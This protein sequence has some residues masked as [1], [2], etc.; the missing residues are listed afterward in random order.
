MSLT[1]VS[2]K[3]RIVIPKDARAG[4]TAGQTIH[5]FAKDGVI[6]LV[7]DTPLSEM[8]GFVEG[9]ELTGFREK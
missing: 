3:Y 4:I 9:I 6:I 1:T 8:Q 7:P 5:V 2:S